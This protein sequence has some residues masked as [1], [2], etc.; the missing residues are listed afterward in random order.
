MNL[1]GKAGQLQA[2]FRALL[3]DPAYRARGPYKY[4]FYGP[5]G[6]GKSTLALEIAAAVDPHKWSTLTYNGKEVTVA[7]VRQ[8]IDQTQSRPLHGGNIV[9]II[10]EVDRASRDAQ[11]LMLSWLDILPVEAFAIVTSNLELENLQERFQTRFQQI[12]FEKVPHLA[13]SAMLLDLGIPLEEA[14]DIALSAE[15]N[16]RAAL[17]DARTFADFNPEKMIKP[18]GREVIPFPAAKASGDNA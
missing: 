7:Q 6:T 12:P 18:F 17:L 2:K 4:L 3:Q 1:I 5:A 15:G 13:M 11:D 14:E 10:D 8:W 9:W 16:V